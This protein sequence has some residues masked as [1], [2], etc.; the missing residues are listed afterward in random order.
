LRRAWPGLLE[1]PDRPGWA[2][3]V[4]TDRADRLRTVEERIAVYDRRGEAVARQMDPAPRAAAGAGHRT[5]A[6]HGPGGDG[7]QGP[8]RQERPPVCRVA[9]AGA[10]ATFQGGTRRRG[11]ITKRGAVSL[12]TVL[13]HGAR[14]VMRPLARRPD[15]TRRWSTALQA[16]RGFNQAVGARGRHA[17]SPR[18]G[19]AGSG[20]ALSAPC[21][22]PLSGPG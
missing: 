12:R 22:G 13:M 8:R 1:T 21:G 9:G 2:R 6:R 15:A 4:F 14:A 5:G 7:R 17:R 3:E 16:R 10:P 19:A 20:T 11:R 18:G